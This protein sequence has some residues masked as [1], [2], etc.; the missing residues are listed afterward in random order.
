MPYTECRLLLL[1]LLLLSLIII[2]RNWKKIGS[3]KEEE[4]EKKVGKN[5]CGKKSVD[6]PQM[7]N[8]AFKDLFQDEE[9]FHLY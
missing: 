3:R 6:Y 5:P 4:E 9:V 1:L 7:W 8:L 2:I